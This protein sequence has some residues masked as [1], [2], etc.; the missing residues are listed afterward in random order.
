VLGQGQ[1]AVLIGS[2]FTTVEA[3]AKPAEG[4]VRTSPT[5]T[6]APGPGASASSADPAPTTAAKASATTTSTTVVG[7]MPGETPAGVECG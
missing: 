1:V 2:R 4:A 7:H 5:T 3:A 6:A